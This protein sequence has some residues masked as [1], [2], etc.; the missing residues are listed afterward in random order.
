MLSQPIQS[1]FM[2]PDGAEVIVETGKLARQADGT[3]TVRQGKNIYWLLQL[4]VKSQ[5]KDKLSF[6]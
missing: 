2:L 1:S 5:K 6:H 4:Q 3:V